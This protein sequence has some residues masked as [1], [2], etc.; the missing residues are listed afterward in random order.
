[1]DKTLDQLFQ[2]L[3]NRVKVSKLSEP[4][5]SYVN[6]RIKSVRYFEKTVFVFEVVG[7]E[8]P[9]LYDNKYFERRG[10]Q[11]MEVEPKDFGSLF[12]RF[13]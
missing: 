13:K 3:T 9:S 12:S 2:D 8:T 1:M 6:A 7:H 5:R 10:T 11:V 4:L